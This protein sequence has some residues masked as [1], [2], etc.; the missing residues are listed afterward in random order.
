ME[1]EDRYRYTRLHGLT[2]QQSIFNNLS[3]WIQKSDTTIVTT[4]QFILPV[5]L[6]R[7]DKYDLHHVKWYR[8]VIQ[9]TSHPDCHH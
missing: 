6:Q 3:N 9:L 1:L 2:S 8:G 5:N 4:H 7:T